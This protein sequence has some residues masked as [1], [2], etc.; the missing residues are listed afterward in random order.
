M[1]FLNW[2]KARKVKPQHRNLSE[3][4]IQKTHKAV[5]KDIRFLNAEK[6]RASFT[7]VKSKTNEV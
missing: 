3:V 5:V 2:F 1:K 7:V 4:E 6:R